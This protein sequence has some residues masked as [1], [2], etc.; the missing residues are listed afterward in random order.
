MTRK[1][2]R[3]KEAVKYTDEHHSLADNDFQDAMRISVMKAHFDASKW[4]DRTMFDK[5]CEW[6]EDNMLTYYPL[7]VYRDRSAEQAAK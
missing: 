1:E 4:A 6:L 2:E 7:G 5:V 3:F